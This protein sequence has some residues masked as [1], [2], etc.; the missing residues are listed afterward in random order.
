MAPPL[1][2][3]TIL[4]LTSPIVSIEA[5]QSVITTMCTVCID[6]PADTTASS[7]TADTDDQ[8]CKSYTTP[9]NQCYNAQTLFPG[10]ESWSAYDIYDSISMMNMKRTFYKSD[11]GTCS[12]TLSLKEMLESA[13]GAAAGDVASGT[14]DHYITQLDGNDD[15]FILPFDQCVGPFGPPR[16]W[17]K[18]TLV[19]ED[20]LSLDMGGVQDVQLA[21]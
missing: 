12:N 17:G 4:L 5:A 11:D 16:P 7:L 15:Y 10:D 1:L 9:L 21:E 13:E 20:E 14:Y 6:G 18:F 8:R 19:Q 2:L 3:A